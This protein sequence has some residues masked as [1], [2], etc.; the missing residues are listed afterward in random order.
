MSALWIACYVL[1]YLVAVPVM[2]RLMYDPE[3]DGLLDDPR[4]VIGMCVLN[5][6]VWPVWAVLGFAFVVVPRYLGRLI[7]AATPTQGDDE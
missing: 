6:V 3:D 4:L 7:L 1:G 2:A 5:A